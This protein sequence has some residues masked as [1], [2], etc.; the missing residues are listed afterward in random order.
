MRQAHGRHGGRRRSLAAALALPCAC[1]VVS[2]PAAAQVYTWKDAQG[3]THYG[4]A[5]PAGARARALRAGS[6]PAA[7][8]ALPYALARAVQDFPVVLYTSGRC[9]ACDQGRALLRARGIPFTER[10]VG[11]HA[12][13]QV[14]RRLSGKSEV[15]L[16]LVGRQKIAGFQ[17][18]AWD[19]ALTAAAY[20]TASLLPPGYRQAPPQPAAPVVSSDAPPTASEAA[21]R[22]PEPEPDA[23]PPAR[24]R[25]DATPPDFQF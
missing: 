13:E 1:V 2:V 11:T 6:Q 9:D 4:D 25:D 10:T 24:P 8:S 16:L 19:E 21:A 23:H 14:L 12:D 18:A 17:A 15:P 22:Q 20:P 3:V 5:P 7:A